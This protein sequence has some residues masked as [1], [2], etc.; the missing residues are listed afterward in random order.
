MPVYKEK[1]K[2][3]WFIVTR[4]HD[5][6]GKLRTTTKRGFKTKAEAKRYE[7]EFA[8]KKENSLSMTFGS[9]AEIYLDSMKNRIRE[10]TYRS[11]AYILEDKILPYFKDKKL[12][13]ITPTDVIQWQDAIMNEKDAK[14]EKYSPTYL[15]TIHN[16]LSAIFNYA[17]RF[18]GLKDNPARIAGNMSKET[19]VLYESL[20]Y[21]HLSEKC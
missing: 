16:Q 1:N 7:A 12:C 3:P 19:N 6:T 11:K 13:D 21:P 9:F 20:Y 18:Y 17:V 15:K 14:G 4:Y 10:N 2:N 8:Q 5:W